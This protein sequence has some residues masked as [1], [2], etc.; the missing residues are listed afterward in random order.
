MLT[1]TATVMSKKPIVIERLH[2]S[3][4][5]RTRQSKN[6]QPQHQTS[7]KILSDK[8]HYCRYC[9]RKRDES[10]M[11]VTGRAAFGKDSWTCLD[12]AGCLSIQ[13]VKFPNMVNYIL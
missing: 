5:V 8:R 4:V 2:T 7:N 6:A 11:E 10:F 1:L 3:Y 12:G 9:K 13:K